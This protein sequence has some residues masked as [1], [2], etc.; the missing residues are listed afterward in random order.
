V[1][2]EPLR[3]SVIIPARN[4]IANL[5]SVLEMVAAQTRRPDEVVIADGMSTDGSRQFLASLGSSPVAITVVDNP[6]RIVSAALNRALEAATGDL[7]ARM[8]THAHYPANYLETVTSF[9]EGH[10]EIDGVGGAMATEG[11][12]RWGKA[13]A[14]TLRRPL[15]LGGARHRVG[16]ASGP[17]QHVFSGCYRRTALERIGGWDERF[18][19]NEDFEADL[20]VADTGGRLWLHSEANTTWFVRE[21]LP[22]LARQMW[23]YGWYKGQTL[24]LH[25]RSLKPRQLVP[26]ALVVGL[27][28]SISV[29]PRMGFGLTAG[30]LILAGAYG[31]KVASADGA[32]PWRGSLV[33]PV[34]HLCWGSGALAGLVRFSSLVGQRHDH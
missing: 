33:P 11:R 10:P 6:D 22:K 14:A 28:A 16:G 8:D 24:H 4:E 30:Y 21:S 13:I 7:I 1:T 9:L 31:A 20:R 26:P 23:R 12:G 25:P 19:A 34:V 15:G 5:P 29:R 32:D 27:L 3:V 17:I 2:A 18:A